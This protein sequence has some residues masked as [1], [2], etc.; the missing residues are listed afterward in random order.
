MKLLSERLRWG[1]ERR[2]AKS[3][4][5]VI[6]ADIARAAHVSDTS[7]HN[8]LNDQ[9]GMSAPKSRLIGEYLGVNP[10]WLESGE[11]IPCEETQDASQ[12]RAATNNL[13]FPTI[14]HATIK[15][16]DK[17]PGYFFELA[18]ADIPPILFRKDWYSSR[19]YKPADLLAIKVSGSS[20]EPNLFDGDTVVINIADTTPKDDEVFVVNYEGAVI[21]RRLVRTPG[22]WWLS[23]DH[24]DQRRYQRKLFAN[25][26]NIV[27]RVVLKQSERI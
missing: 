13:E 11:G 17:A 1:M 16:S 24:I 12:D 4:I 18:G 2:Q 3:G 19:N 26:V 20:M 21:V 10:L 9:N 22:E 7:A 25:E 8:W 23:S 6:P 5:E 14:K 27:G 15:L